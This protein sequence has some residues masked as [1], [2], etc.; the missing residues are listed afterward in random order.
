MIYAGEKCDWRAVYNVMTPAW[1][2]TAN[3]GHKISAF[4]AVISGLVRDHNFYFFQSFLIPSALFHHDL[5]VVI[6][7]YAKCLD[8]LYAFSHWYEGLGRLISYA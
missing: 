3:C 2:E 5:S 1:F 6:K 7:D 4:I 8:H